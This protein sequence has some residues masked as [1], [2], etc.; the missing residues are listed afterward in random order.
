MHRMQC[1]T[2]HRIR[3][4][5]LPVALLVGLVAGCAGPRMAAVPPPAA[6]TLDDLR[7]GSVSCYDRAASPGT[8]IVDAHVHF[9]PFGGPAVPFGDVLD[10]FRETGVL[11]ANVTG[12]GQSLPDSS[13]CTYYLDC[14]GTPV[15]PSLKNDLQNAADRENAHAPDLHITMAMTFPDLANPSTVLNGMA[16]LDS[17]YPGQFTWMGEVNLVKQALFVNSHEAVLPDSIAAWAPFM[18]EL[19][20]RGMPLAL[21]SDLGNDEDP[22]RYVALMEEVLRLY[23]DNDIVWMHLGLSRELTSMNPDR[24]VAIL[25][26]FL[27]RFSNLYMDISWRVLDDAYF[28]EPTARAAYI[29]FLNRYSDRILPGSDF[30]ASADKDFEV[31]RDELVITSHILQYLS[32]EAFRNI[33]LG[34]NYFRLLDLEYSAPPIC[35][36]RP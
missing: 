18:Q 7:S 24:H 2:S 16:V 36:E 33:A 20:A 29:P 13:S 23:P 10:Y 26:S 28:S 9:R 22:E 31:Y 1:V 4:I 21:H 15:L 6:L 3:W 30:L 32:D 27:A 25:S 19:R 35:S 11:F 34:E 8:A 12:I 14:P 17:L 5:V